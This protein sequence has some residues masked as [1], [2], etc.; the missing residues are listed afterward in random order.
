MRYSSEHKRQTRERIVRAAS[1][2]FRAKGGKGLA[3]GDLMEKLDLTHG[4]FYRHFG[5]KDQLFAEALERGFEEAAARL[6]K[7]IEAA[8]PG[9]ELKRIIERY[10]SAE[11][12]ANAA[13]G[14]PFAAMM[15]EMSRYPRGL[16]VRIERAMRAHFKKIAKFLP[17]ATGRERGQNCLILFSGMA[18][19]LNVARAAANPEH[20]DAILRS[21]RAFYIKA[22]CE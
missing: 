17:G 11:H 12:C 18:G 8:P 21:A 19:A 1:R 16:R 3:I 7:G 10:L 6:G 22:F 2:Q 13:D 14:C 4:G 5:S 9:S 15:S 20:R